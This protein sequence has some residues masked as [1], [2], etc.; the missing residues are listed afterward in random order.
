[1]HD[2]RSTVEPT[3]AT[4]GRNSAGWVISTTYQ[5]AYGWD[6]A[7]WTLEV[8]S[9]QLHADTGVKLSCSY[10][11]Q[12]LRRWGCR[13]GRPRP[14]LRIP[15]RGRRKLPLRA[16]SGRGAVE[17]FVR[18]GN[19]LTGICG[20]VSDVVNFSRLRGLSILP[21]YLANWSAGLD[22]PGVEQ[23]THSTNALQQVKVLRGQYQ[24]PSAL[25]KL[26]EP[27]L[28]FFDKG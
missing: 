7:N 23:N 8:L 28:G 20:V 22:L 6:R 9:L 17:D 10:V 25:H 4:P 16:P 13:R 15:V 26:F 24:N 5:K 27:P 12:L 3:K 21:Q 11:Y 18:H 14:G 19:S 2:Q 1:M